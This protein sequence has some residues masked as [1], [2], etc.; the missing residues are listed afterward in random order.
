VS[1]TE[2]GEAGRAFARETGWRSQAPVF[3]FNPPDELSAENG[4]AGW[5]SIFAA[6]KDSAASIAEN[7]VGLPV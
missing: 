6:L 2:F 7:Y 5:T 1:L 4:V 3:D